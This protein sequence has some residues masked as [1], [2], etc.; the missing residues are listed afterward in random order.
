MWQTPLNCF[1]RGTWGVDP[2]T[3]VSAD[4]RAGARKTGGKAGGRARRFSTRTPAF[5]VSCPHACLWINNIPEIIKKQIWS[6][7]HIPSFRSLCR[8]RTAWPI[9]KLDSDALDF[10]IHIGITPTFLYF[11]LYLNTAYAGHYVYLKNKNKKLQ[12][13]TEIAG[14]TL[15]GCVQLLSC[16][17][18][19]IF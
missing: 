12:S 9:T 17:E 14:T 3:D 5:R 4:R 7:I 1:E 8:R 11:D 13:L 2:K 16:W 19:T 18:I 6:I 10:T 15:Q